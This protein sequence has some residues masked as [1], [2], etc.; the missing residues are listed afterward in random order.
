MAWSEILATGTNQDP[1]KNRL[2]AKAS[3]PFH[4]AKRVEKGG[5]RFSASEG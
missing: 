3:S 1:S 4:S 5:R 2:A